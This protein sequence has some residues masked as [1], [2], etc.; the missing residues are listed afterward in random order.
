VSIPQ[1]VDT[2]LEFADELERRDAEAARSLDAVER[3]QHD[4][5]DLRM[6]LTA[7]VEF[8]ASFREAAAARAGELDSALSAR[9][10]AERALRAAETAVERVG[11]EA[12]RLEAERVLQTARDDAHAAARWAAEAEEAVVLFA[13]EAEE[14]RAEGAKLEKRAAELS[15]GVRGVA[16]TG[17]GLGGALDWASRARG[18][19]LLSHAALSGEREMLVREAS[20]LLGSVAGESL[21]TVA[22]AGVREKLESAL[23]TA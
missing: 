6:R 11:R 14:R 8:L 12:A 16:P 21:A 19:L 2:R 20:E 15:G 4:V 18:A 10:G 7:V 17:T 9:V 23:G 13:R 1:S 22:V 5:D 3:L